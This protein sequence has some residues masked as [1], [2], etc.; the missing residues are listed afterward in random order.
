LTV[1]ACA[2]PVSIDAPFNPNPWIEDLHEARSALADKYAN[3]AWVVKERDFDLPA[4]FTE[5]EARVRDVRSG[6][7]AR[8]V[9]DRL[10]RSLGDAHVRIQW[11][12]GGGGRNAPSAAGYAEDT[13]QRLGYENA[14]LGQPVAASLPGYAPLSNADASEFPAGTL[15]FETQTLGIIRIGFFGPE[16]SPRLCQSALKRLAIAAPS[17]CNAA[18]ATRIQ[19]EAYVQLSQDLA[20]R[21]RALRALGARILLI[22]LTANG[23]GS[24]WAEAAARMVSPLRLQ[25]ERLDFV[26][27]T[28]WA[29]IWHVLAQKL[30]KAEDVASAED[31]TQLEG[32]AQEVDHAYAQALTPCSSA[33]LWSGGQL[34]CEWL[35]HGFY[36]TGI[37][38]EADARQLRAKPWG[39]LVFSPAQYE[40]ESHVWRGPVLVLVDAKT[41]S[42]AEEFAA[43]L[44][45]NKAAIIIGA[46]TA[47][48]GCGHTDGGTPTVLHGTNA[49]LELPDCARVRADNSNEVDGIDPDVL[50]GFRSAD[51]PR[52]KALRLQAVL[53]SSIARAD[54]L[55]EQHRCQVNL[56]L[57]AP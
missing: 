5:A 41:G 37:L 32:W 52:R 50:I 1:V 53:E 48:A 55:C 44:Q 10:V 54:R 2:G 22:D 51:S 43:V 25:S 31:R 56:R 47:G 17:P 42:A 8:E 14:K 19:A 39:K 16:R 28:H 11:E 40:F 30:R 29:S 23:G 34:R 15:K 4:A 13:C 24:E 7:A 3:L 6:A 46:P 35:A 9:I 27:G 18:C 21:V 49:I 36:A 38:G 12:P 26:R 20:S 45:D 57:H 33:P